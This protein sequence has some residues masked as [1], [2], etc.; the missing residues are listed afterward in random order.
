MTNLNS[1]KEYNKQV[2]ECLKALIYTM[3]RL[4]VQLDK[5]NFSMYKYFLL[6]ILDCTRN[7]KSHLKYLIK[8][9]KILDFLQD[10]L[11]K[12][13]DD[14][15]FAVNEFSDKKVLVFSLKMIVCEIFFNLK[16]DK[17]FFKLQDISGAI[18][19]LIKFAQRVL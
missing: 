16:F 19:L 4:V 9:K 12:E 11:A 7:L 14:F 8:V 2:Q 1:D 10:V 5:E 17:E 3:V 18:G 15:Q 13:A 6:A